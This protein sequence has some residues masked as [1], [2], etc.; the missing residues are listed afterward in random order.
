MWFTDRRNDPDWCVRFNADFGD[1]GRTVNGTMRPRMFD[2]LPE[3]VQSF[4]WYN[5]LF[6]VTGEMRR[7]FYATYS[8]DYINPSYVFGASLGLL[9][10]GLMLLHRDSDD[11]IH[12]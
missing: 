3:W 12:K 8:P 11:L 7:G 1:A 6:H 5:P 4:L 10:L 9:A 2:D